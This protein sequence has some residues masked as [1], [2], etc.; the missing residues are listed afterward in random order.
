ML[1]FIRRIFSVFF[2][3]TTTGVVV[4]STLFRNFPILYKLFIALYDANNPDK[5]VRVYETGY[6][7]QTIV[8]GRPVKEKKKKI[9]DKNDGENIAYQEYE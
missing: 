2:M 4:V 1:A 3:L 5:D 6:K 7:D 9:F 8:D